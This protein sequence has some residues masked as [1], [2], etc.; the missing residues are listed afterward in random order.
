MKISIIFSDLTVEEAE[1]FMVIAV[2]NS[3]LEEPDSESKPRRKRRTK[4]EMEQARHEEKESAEQTAPEGEP[5]PRRRRKRGQEVASP[6]KEPTVTGTG[7]STTRSHSEDAL[8]DKDV[9]RKASEGAQELTPKVVTVLLEEFGVGHVGELDQEQRRE[10]VDSIDEKL[11]EQAVEPG[12]EAA[13]KP[14]RRKR[15]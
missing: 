3:P 11:V 15:R 2:E 8:T 9:M 10:F 14:R 5:A 13:P 7:I 4:A 1:A 6:T 12:R